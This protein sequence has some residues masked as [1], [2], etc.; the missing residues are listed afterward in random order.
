MSLSPLSFAVVVGIETNKGKLLS[1]LLLE[2]QF[3]LI[4]HVFFGPESVS[5]RKKGLLSGNF[6]DRIF[7]P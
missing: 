2:L 3:L 5:D 4:Y 6:A 1:L 7:G